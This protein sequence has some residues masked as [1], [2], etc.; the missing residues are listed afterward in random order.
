MKRLWCWLRY[1]GHH[2]IHHIDPY[3]LY[4]RWR[5]RCGRVASITL[6]LLAL[7]AASAAA[8]TYTITRDFGGSVYD[9]GRRWASLR[10]DYVVIDGHCYSSC[11]MALGNSPNV[12]VTRRSVLGFHRAYVWT[13]FGYVTSEAGTD[14]M[15]RHYPADIQLLLKKRGGLLADRG[16]WWNPALLWVKGSELPARYRCKS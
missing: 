8:K 6:V 11:T 15:W 2:Y 3:G 14:Y 5:D 9:Y 12:C 1:G 7:F 13:V 4:W 16:G 10:G